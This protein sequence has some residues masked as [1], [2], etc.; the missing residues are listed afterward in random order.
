VPVKQGR[1]EKLKTGIRHHADSSRYG[2]YEP[3]NDDNRLLTTQQRSRLNKAVT[4][5]RDIDEVR[6][7]AAQRLSTAWDRQRAKSDASLRR[8][9]S[10]IPKKE[11]PKKADPGA[12]T[13]SE[14]RVKRQALMA[15]MLNNR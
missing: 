2:G 13:V 7:S 9:P 5:D 15:Q 1:I 8:T 6:T 10:S 14:H 4:P 3:E 12:K 11:E